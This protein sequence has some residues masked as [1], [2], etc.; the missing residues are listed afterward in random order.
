MA[1]HPYLRL[2]RAYLEEFLPREGCEGMSAAPASGGARQAAGVPRQLAVRAAPG[3]QLHGKGAQV[4]PQCH[5]WICIPA[6]AMLQAAQSALRGARC[7]RGM[8]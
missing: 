1:G 2:L 4:R 5:A 6:V 3:G 7:I 8:G